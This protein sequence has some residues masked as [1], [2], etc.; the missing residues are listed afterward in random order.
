L[1]DFV[2]LSPGDCV[3]QNGANS[4]VGQAV[5]QIAAEMSLQTINVIRANR[6]NGDQLVTYLKS[7]GATHVVTDEFVRS[8]EM[9]NLVKS[10]PQ[11]PP[12]LAFNCVAGRSVADLLKHLAKGANV[13]TYGGM[14]KQPM[15]VPVGPLIFNDIHLRGYWNTRWYSENQNT[16]KSQSMWAFLSDMIHGG[17]LK[18]PVYRLVQLKDYS[19]AVDRAMEPFL[20]EKQILVFNE[21]VL[22]K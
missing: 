14:S 10:L 15:S 5:I 9:K 17:R 6:P 16:E 19:S 21:T 18:A 7:L 8:P 13:V 4:G 3:I 12:K 22:R 11:G 1:V 2:S 20:T